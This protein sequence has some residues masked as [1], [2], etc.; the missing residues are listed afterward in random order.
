MP[1]PGM[2]QAKESRGTLLQAWGE[3]ILR[4]PGTAGVGQGPRACDLL[5]L[6]VLVTHD[7]LGTP[8][9]LRTKWGS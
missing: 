4:I 8:E 2:Y 1:A 6:R 3:R 5:V 7:P 9:G